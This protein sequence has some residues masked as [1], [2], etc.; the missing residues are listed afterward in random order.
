MGEDLSRLRKTSLA[1][2]VVHNGALVQFQQGKIIAE[3]EAVSIE[4]FV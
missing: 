1:D 3:R 4:V 2:A